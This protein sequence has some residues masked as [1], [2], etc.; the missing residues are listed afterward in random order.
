M[1]PDFHSQPMP[2]REAEYTSAIVALERSFSKGAFNLHQDAVHVLVIQT[3]GAKH[4]EVH[5]PYGDR[6][7]PGPVQAPE[8]AIPVHDLT[9]HKGD[10]FYMPPGRPHRAKAVDGWSLHVSITAE[11]VMARR[12]LQEKLGEMMSTLSDFELPALWSESKSDGLQVIA[13]DLLERMKYADW[14]F[15]HPAPQIREEHTQDIAHM[16]DLRERS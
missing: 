16:L 8:G 1:S 10:I 15:V 14:R 9:L 6:M 7:A 4:W 12:V 11:P 3:E 2:A 13:E 5:N